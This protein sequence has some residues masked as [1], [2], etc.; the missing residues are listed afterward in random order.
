M[1]TRL[2]IGLLIIIL[3]VMGFAA[4]A[5]AAASPD[6]GDSDALRRYATPQG[7]AEL[8][9][10]GNRPYL[11][12]DVR[13]AAEYASGHIPTAIN[14]PYDRIASGLQDQPTDR[15]LV[16]YCRTGRRSGIALNELRRLGYSDI[17]DFGGISR[18]NGAMV[19]P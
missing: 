16:L 8:I 1:L 6:A 13:T 19:R 2:L 11:L 12:V 14:I 18:W 4:I 9:R 10:H 7:L 3:G 17:V 5:R 15:L